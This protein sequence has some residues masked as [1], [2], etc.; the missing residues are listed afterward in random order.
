MVEVSAGI[1]KHAIN[2]CIPDLVLPS[3]PVSATSPIGCHCTGSLHIFSNPRTP[4]YH[5]IP[6]QA[7]VYYLS[8]MGCTRLGLEWPEPVQPRA[9]TRIKTLSRSHGRPLMRPQLLACASTA[10][11][12]TLVSQILG[13]HLCF[14]SQ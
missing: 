3:L 9:A 11:F 8:I 12:P 13:I 6:D 10:H 4:S 2:P 5:C 7:C 14:N 1:L